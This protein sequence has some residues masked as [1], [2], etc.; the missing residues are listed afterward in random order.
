MNQRTINLRTENP[1][2]HLQSSKTIGQDFFAVQQSAENLFLLSGG[3]A[4]GLVDG[5]AVAGRFSRYEGKQV[6][7]GLSLA[8]PRLAGDHDGLRLALRDGGMVGIAGN[9]RL[10]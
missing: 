4:P 9:L 6:F 1:L 7:G 10:W 5:V 8:R 2:P 3:A